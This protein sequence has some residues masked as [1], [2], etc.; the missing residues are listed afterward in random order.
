MKNKNKSR[1]ESILNAS[2]L[3]TSATGFPSFDLAELNLD[4][5]VDYVLPTNLRLGH[6]A[7]R[8]VSELI[9][10]STNYQV[11]YENVQLLVDRKTIGEID[12]IIEETKTKQLIHLELAYKFYLYDPSITDVPKNNWIGPNRNDSLIEKLE[13]LKIR[14]FPLLYHPCANA[15]FSDL[16]TDEISQALCLLASLFIPYEYKGSFPPAYEKAVKGYYIGIEKFT[17]L[18]NSEKNYYLPIKSEW[19]MEPIDNEDW[20]DFKGIEKDI[21]QSLAENQA[22]LC[23]QKYKEKYSAFFIVWW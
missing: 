16:K 22:R 23:W 21:I 18:H 12:F 9:K 3:D 19:G 7:E 15:V 13:K 17:Y 10:S 1:I 11:R 14:Q 20:W 4:T 5:V 6:L 8:I 2:S